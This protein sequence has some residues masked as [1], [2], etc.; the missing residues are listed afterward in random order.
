[1]YSSTTHI[2]YSFEFKCIFFA[3]LNKNYNKKPSGH[4]QLDRTFIVLNYPGKL[5]DFINYNRLLNSGIALRN[6]PSRF[7]RPKINVTFR[8]SKPLG[9]EICNNNDICRSTDCNQL[10]DIITKQCDCTSSTY[11]YPPLNHIV[12]GNLNYI[13]NINLRNIMEKGYK[14]MQHDSKNT[15]C[16]IKDF[17]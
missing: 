13:T 1:M 3:F 5:Y 14:F 12:T 4:F 15:N 7:T 2:S 11:K 6:W 17:K 10:V 9:V 16:L 8:L